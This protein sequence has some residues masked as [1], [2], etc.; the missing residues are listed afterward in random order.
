MIWLASY[1]RSG[2]T[3]L[4]IVLSEVYGLQSSTLHH[5]ADYPVDEDYTSYPLVKTHLLPQQLDPSEPSIPA[6]Y[7]VRDGRDCV[8]SMAH[9]RKDLIESQSQLNENLRAVIEAEDGSHFGGW[10]AHVR[11]WLQ[12]A[13]LVIRFEDLIEDPIGQ[14]E[15][16]RPFVALPK[17]HVDRLP[18]FDDLQNRSYA[19]GSGCD[20]GLD[21][22]AQDQMRRSK[23]RRG[24]AGGW[25]DILPRR[26]ELL[27]LR[28]H[29]H[30]LRQLGYPTCDNEDA[31]NLDQQ[32]VDP[33]PMFRSR[34]RPHRVLIDGIKLDDVR[35]DG[36]RRYSQGLLTAL[37]AIEQERPEQWQFA[38]CLRDRRVFPLAEIAA[39]LE[40]GQNI[41]LGIVERAAK[42]TDGRPRWTDPLR[43]TVNRA[44]R[45]AARQA[46]LRAAA[47]LT[48]R[49][50]RI[51]EAQFD[52]LHLC[53]P[54]VWPHYA[55]VDL[56]R[57]TTVHDLSHM[58]RPETMTIE[59]MKTLRDGLDAAVRDESEFLA[60]SSFTRQE[61][62]DV[63]NFAPERVHVSLEG[64][65][66]GR[67]FPETRAADLAR[68]RSC[69]QL[70]NTPYLLALG[71]LEPRKNLLRMVQAFRRVLAANPTLEVA[72]LIAGQSGWGSTRDWAELDE[73]TGVQRL[74][75]VAEGDL[76]GLYT[77]A[78]A[79]CYVSHY[80]GFGLPPLEA[81]GC[82]TPVIFGD[83][84]AVPEVVGDAGLGVRADDEA[85]IARA[86]ERLLLDGELRHQLARRAVMRSGALTWR[87]AAERTLDAYDAAI[88]RGGRRRN[89]PCPQ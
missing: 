61:L 1:P 22:K 67:F 26:F 23:F 19:Y 14:I 4:R 51:N 50:R 56:P 74:G 9:Y 66:P 89:S 24:R 53:L 37:H 18:T 42:A 25:V 41:G 8:V 13:Q 31:G 30:V 73:T 48:R 44:R 32:A 6:V 64:S 16:L 82:G 35:T 17:P 11:A 47:K 54:N 84:S 52:L 85:A 71:T 20:H 69:C 55:D 10:S 36:I 57:V 7:L 40:P 87:A 62:L 86:M 39:F 2:N 15:R 76:A 78:A 27:F 81:M 72:F 46:W 80:E 60:V 75:H 59:N 12:R 49:R 79:F 33:T 65:D 68:V 88:A 45:V 21:D 38:V 34:A 28:R 70:P 3:F 77:E 58:R 83:G 5:E 43:N 63:Y 29:G